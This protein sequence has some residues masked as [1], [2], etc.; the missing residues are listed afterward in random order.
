MA[1]GALFNPQRAEGARIMP[2][3]GAAQGSD[4]PTLREAGAPK[5]GAAAAARRDIRSGTVTSR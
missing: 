2:E 1:F 5:L 3:T 4:Y